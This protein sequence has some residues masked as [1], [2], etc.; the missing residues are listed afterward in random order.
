MIAP[1]LRCPCHE[2]RRLIERDDRLACSGDG[3]P[4]ASAPGLFA[5]S[6]GKPILIA[7]EKT[8]T[9]WTSMTNDASERLFAGNPSMLREAARRLFYGV[10]SRTRKNCVRFVD[11]LKQAN[12]SEVLV[13][14]SGAKGSGTEALWDDSLL[15]RTG[16]D[17]YASPTVDYVAD[18]HFLPFADASFDGVWIQAVLE[19]V[20]SPADV[21]AEIRRVL[22]PG[23]V[24]YAE[25]PFMQQV[26]AGPYDFTRYTVTGHRFLFRDFR[27]LDMGGN[28]GPAQVLAW[29]VKYLVWSLTKSRTAGVAA[30]LPAFL[31]ARAID[32]LIADA[33]LW[34]ACSGVYFLGVKDEDG[35]ARAK[36]LPSLY[37][38]L[39][40]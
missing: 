40:H 31:L 6:F 27:L 21:V 34:D 16:V 11:L 33:A 30:S 7:F 14:G 10:S 28:G 17:I 22:K 9:L 39:Q 12:R 19:H 32:P 36:D 15:R 4:H 5:I 13:I 18:A 24:V 25:T 35:A 1:K 29:S 3:C 26:H 37:Q 20:A 8:D 23:G 38:G 2:K